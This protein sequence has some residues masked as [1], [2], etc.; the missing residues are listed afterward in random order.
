MD[1]LTSLAAILDFAI[2]ATLWAVSECP[3]AGWLV[4][5]KS[6]LTCLYCE[7]WLLVQYAN[8]IM[9]PGPP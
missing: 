7:E 3:G 6:T 1:F 2:G 9:Q 5:L 4:F 8:I